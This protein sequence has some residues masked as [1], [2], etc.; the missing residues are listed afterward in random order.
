MKARS[1]KRG[2]LD[3]CNIDM[4]KQDEENCESV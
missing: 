4:H 2:T 1:G 3:I